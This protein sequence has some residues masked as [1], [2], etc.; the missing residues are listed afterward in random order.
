M[1][2]VLVTQLRGVIKLAIDVGD[3]DKDKSRFSL[4]VH[5]ETVSL[6]GEE[7]NRH[8]RLHSLIT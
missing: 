6:A 1:P 5:Y 8:I 2:F 4:K 3:L 7:E